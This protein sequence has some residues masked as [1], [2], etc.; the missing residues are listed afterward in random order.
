MTNTVITKW[1]KGMKFETTSPN[2][3]S[4]TLG[5]NQDG[6]QINVPTQKALMIS[7]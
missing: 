2:G 3:V 5:S 7:S 6:D 4:I 1:S